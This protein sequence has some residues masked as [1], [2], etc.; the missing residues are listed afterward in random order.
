LILG[1]IVLFGCGSTE[2]DPKP[3]ERDA[4][5]E[6]GGDAS[7]LPRDSGSDT[8]ARSDVEG[9]DDACAA[10]SCQTDARVDERCAS[11][12]DCASEAHCDDGHCQTDVCQP[13]QRSCDG[14]TVLE[15]S[16]NGATRTAR[17]ACASESYFESTCHD[18]AS[19]AGSCSCEDDWDC[20]AFTACSTGRCDGTGVAPTCSLPPTPFSATPPTV[21]L[22]WGGE[23]RDHA[24]AH[25]G[26]P[27]HALA[28]WPNFSQVLDT[29]MVANLDDDNGDGL[30]NELD[31][32]EILFVAHQ[33]D[34]AWS[35]GVVRAIH[36]GG[37][38]KGADAFARC[39]DKLWTK[40]KPSSE[41]CADAD[42]DADSGAPLAVADLDGD[43]TPEIVYTTENNTFR[44][45]DHTGALEYTLP[46]P[47]AA[48]ADG[49]SLAIANLD[50][51]GYAEIIVGGTVYVLGPD[52]DSGI[53]VTHI[54]SGNKAIGKNDLSS[55]ACPADIIAARPGQEI[56]A[57]GTLYA[58]PARLPTCANTPC[59][60]ALDVVWDAKSVRGNAGI[61]GEGFCAVA[62]VWGS[63]PT[64]P[65]GPKN[66]PDGQPEV[67]LIDNGHLVILNSQTGA[68][69]VDRNL[70]GGTRGGA[71]NVDDFDGDGFMEVASAL[72]NFYVVVDLQ[73]S[74]GSAG[75]CP[76]W[77]ATIE[78]KDQPLGAHNTNPPRT[79]GGTCQRDSEC[80]AAAVC[81]RSIGRCVCLHNGWQ[82]STDDSSSAATSSSVF[83]FNGDGAAEALYND[84]CEFRVYDGRSGEVLFAQLSRSRTAI[85][86]PVVADV[87]NDGNAEVVTVMNTAAAN[88]CDDDPG[89]IPEGPNG[90]R[91]WGDPTDTWVSARR[92]WNEQSYHVTNV[93]ESA[94][95]PRHPVES[96]HS[97]GGRPYNTYRSQPRNAGVAPDLTV[98]A[99][100]V[101]SPGAR[102]GELGDSIDIAFE[103]E[104]RGGLRVGPGVVVHFY[105]SW[106]GTEELLSNG[107][108][109]P[110]ESVLQQSLE[111]G[112]SV[113]LTAHFAAE[114]A[115]H[116]QLPS[117]VRVVVDPSSIA[118]PNGAAREC[119]ED[120]NTATAEVNAAGP[121]AD[122]ALELGEV[123]SDCPAA[124][125][126]TLVRNLG[127]APAQHVVVRYYAGD[128]AQGGSVLHE[129]RL[130][131]PLGPGAERRFTESLQGLPNRGAITVFAVVDPDRTIDE[132]N[133]ANN[134]AS[135]DSEILCSIAP[136]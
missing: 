122:L 126:E 39:G 71:P 49:E 69:I 2:R 96:W 85:E 5:I 38:N 19:A 117:H 119:R 36:G 21:E 20:P 102:C 125:V 110:L 112:R 57:G 37:P 124:E 91:V 123:V 99:V 51:Q 61:S 95:I 86:N 134:R 14:A 73:E 50:F 83:D 16:K 7:V 135:A 66:R 106:D 128:P 136:D 114:D 43:G 101:S 84:E 25:D 133:E 100:S 46:E 87:D 34:N 31:F 67:I 24:A 129:E 109:E 111:P 131:E 113:V 80:D 93:T 82:R 58:M 76:D 81:N 70:G 90:V 63:D 22:Q 68:I 60:L 13:G 56:V 89:G 44:I 59:K 97:W 48:M 33:G 6:P 108:G 12:G 55:M 130:V 42:P 116:S 78:R 26:T 88:R 29:P 104:N 11:D 120:N 62:D 47:W 41:A 98:V 54:L 9:G 15:C 121:R 103:V 18:G 17:Y 107:A 75:N 4:A 127:S 27:E 79:P 72:Q 132:C 105:G 77:P 115:R 40:A 118:E 10:G 35:N 53:K 64:R 28:P 74:T 23:S 3:S 65:P 92:I 1:A 32:P 30:I 94:A 52:G 8:A 45:L